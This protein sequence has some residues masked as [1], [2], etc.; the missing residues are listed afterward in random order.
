MVFANKAKFV[1][2]MYLIGRELSIGF[3]QICHTVSRQAL[4]AMSGI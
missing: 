1:F 4:I 3:E 2:E